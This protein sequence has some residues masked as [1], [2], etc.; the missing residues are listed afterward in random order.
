MH[1]LERDNGQ[2]Y[3]MKR[4]GYHLIASIAS[5]SN[6]FHFPMEWVRVC[7]AASPSV[8]QWYVCRSLCIWT[9]APFVRT[10]TCKKLFFIIKNFIIALNYIFHI[11][12]W[13]TTHFSEKNSSFDLKISQNEQTNIQTRNEQMFRRVCIR[14]THFP[15]KLNERAHLSSVVV[16]VGAKPPKWAYS[17][18]RPV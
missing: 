14:R 5:N 12:K 17:W 10:N 18:G 9:S 16:V 11:N 6:R 13:K 8:V 3:W 15:H 4:D 1:G 7:R 2:E